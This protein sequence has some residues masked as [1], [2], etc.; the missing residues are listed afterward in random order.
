MPF[1]TFT[2]SS[3][4]PAWLYPKILVLT[5]LGV[6]TGRAAAASPV[7]VH[8]EKA[9][10]YNKLQHSEIGELTTLFEQFA[11]AVATPVRAALTKHTAPGLRCCIFL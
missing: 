6:T 8:P 5:H 10:H 7:W 4:R 2:Y 9:A 11:E 1:S 3:P